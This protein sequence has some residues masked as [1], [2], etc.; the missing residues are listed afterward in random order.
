MNIYIIFMWKTAFLSMTQKEETT[1]EKMDGLTN[2][3][4]K[5]PIQWKISQIRRKQKFKYKQQKVQTC[6]IYQ[7]FKFHYFDKFPW[8][9]IPYPP[10]C[11]H[12]IIFFSTALFHYC[13]FHCLYP[14]NWKFKRAATMSLFAYCYIFYT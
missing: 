11:C 4:S 10:K 13:L 2:W 7:E 9:T 1:K 5:T 14:Q 8:F 12:F 6:N 3:K